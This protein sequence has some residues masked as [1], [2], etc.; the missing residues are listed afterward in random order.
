M[1]TPTGAPVKRALIT[2]NVPADVDPQDLAI[3]LD[4]QL[5]RE[6]TY[7]ANP[8]GSYGN[9]VDSTVYE[10]EGAYLADLEEIVCR[11]GPCWRCGTEVTEQFDRIALDAGQRN[12]C[13]EAD[14]Y[15]TPHEID[16][17]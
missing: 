1:S 5:P 7:G 11:T 17:P 6:F 10:S 8:D 12:I 13:P 2:V 3:Y 4:M 9:H 16:E 14:D 15:D